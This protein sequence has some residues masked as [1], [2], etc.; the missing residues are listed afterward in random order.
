[1]SKGRCPDLCGGRRAAVEQ[2]SADHRSSS[3]LAGLK[4]LNYD[5][6]ITFIVLRTVFFFVFSDFFRSIR[7]GASAESW[8]KLS[9][10]DQVI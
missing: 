8:Q 5:T 2:V 7:S 1:M 6:I 9:P 4:M 3:P 10:I